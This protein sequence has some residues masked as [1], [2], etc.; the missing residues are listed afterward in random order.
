VV[1]T[2]FEDD[3]GVAREGDEKYSG[4]TVT[5]HHFYGVFMSNLLSV[6][7]TMLGNARLCDRP[8]YLALGDLEVHVRSNSQDLLDVLHHYFRHIV[9]E[10][11]TGLES[12]D[13]TAIEC[14]DLDLDLPFKHWQRDTGKVGKKDAYIDMNTDM[15]SARL[16]YKVRTGMM[17]LQSLTDRIAAGPCLANSNQVINFINNQYINYLQNNG[18]LI[19][20]AAA[21]AKDNEGMAFAAFSGGGKSTTMLHLMAD[22]RF[23]FVSN[24]RLFIRQDAD[25]VQAR[26]IPKLPRVN[27]GTLLNNPHLKSI[28]EPEKSQRLQAMPASELWDLEDKYDVD[29]S[30]IYGKSRFC[31]SPMLKHFF[32][33]NWSHQN[34]G[35]THIDLIQA[36]ERADLLDAIMKSSGPFYQ[37]ADGSFYRE[38]T[39]LVHK[40]YAKVLQNIQV[41][42]VHGGINFEAITDF[43]THHLYP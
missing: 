21:L 22:E 1:D 25:G 34:K 30:D 14:P 38:G 2:A 9:C 26:G 17:F 15:Q 29:I 12:V 39:D 40:T 33:L 5:T 28:L 23:D 24:D 11:P 27:P 13:V 42:E 8:L 36:D 20:H 19:C 31:T 6:R 3:E 32:I 35:L 10:Q 37:Y 18:H 4:K 7:Q 43:C 16:I 41:Y